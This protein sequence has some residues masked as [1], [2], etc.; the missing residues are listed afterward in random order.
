MLSCAG[1]M[2]RS[3]QQ[4]VRT[5]VGFETSRLLTVDVSLP[6]KRYANGESLS[7]FYRAASSASRRA[8]RGGR[9]GRGQPA[10]ALVSSANFWIAGRP[11][12]PIDNLPIADIAR[13]T[14]GYFGLIGL[15]LHS[16]RHFTAHDLTESEKEK[17]F[18]T[19]VNQTFARQ[20]FPREN[21]LGKRL[22]TADRKHAGTSWAW[23]R[24][25]G[26]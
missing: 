21:P 10:A 22:L 14:P 2:L 11:D 8:R 20:F 6:E 13:V 24:I 15:P 5:G 1:L 25:T 4:L 18:A 17:D 26:R 9:G 3:F 12:P 7:R 19:I 23:S 16:G